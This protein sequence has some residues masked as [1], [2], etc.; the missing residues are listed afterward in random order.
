MITTLENMRKNFCVGPYQGNCIAPDCNACERYPAGTLS[1]PKILYYCGLSQSR[2]IR[3]HPEPEE[4][5]NN[6]LEL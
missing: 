5:C 2:A 4:E 6:V 1:H 3:L